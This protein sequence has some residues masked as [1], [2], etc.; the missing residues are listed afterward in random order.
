MSVGED[1]KDPGTDPNS[2]DAFGNL[3]ITRV[4]IWEADVVGI[5]TVQLDLTQRWRWDGATTRLKG[6][7]A[8]GGV[9][10]VIAVVA[11]A[12]SQAGAFSESLVNM[13]ASMRWTVFGGE[14]SALILMV[15]GF[16]FVAPSAIRMSLLHSKARSVVI[17]VA[18][19]GLLLVSVVTAFTIGIFIFPMALACVIGGGVLL[20]ARS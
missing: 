12:L 9:G 11:F 14:F 10:G 17:I 8:L 19:L 7:C 6:L 13:P 3:S 5:H 15:L 2:T 16:A 18:A 4:S 1:S 20:F